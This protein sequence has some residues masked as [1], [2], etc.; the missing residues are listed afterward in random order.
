MIQNLSCERAG[1]W[2]NKLAHRQG[3]KLKKR[4][5]FDVDAQ[6]GTGG[7]SKAEAKQTINFLSVSVRVHAIK[8]LMV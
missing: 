4:N 7:L 6:T 3:G 5:N 8:P 1:R 2:R